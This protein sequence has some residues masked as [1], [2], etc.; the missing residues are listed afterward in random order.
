LNEAVI[1]E[2]AK[3]GKYE[4]MVAGLARMCSAPVELV[5]KLMQNTRYDGVLV[6]CKAAGLHWQ[7]FSAI[8][9]KRYSHHQ[10]SAMELE[11]ARTDFIKLSA[12]TAQRMLRFWLVRGVSNAQTKQTA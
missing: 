4:E 12:V 10:V 6:A 11:K 9:S 3:A 2:F 1:V 5:E 8:L 7:T